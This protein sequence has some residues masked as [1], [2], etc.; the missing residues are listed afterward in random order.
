MC[1]STEAARKQRSVGIGTFAARRGISVREEYGTP[2]PDI[3]DALRWTLRRLGI[4]AD[5]RD[6]LPVNGLAYV[7]PLPQLRGAIVLRP[8]VP[9]PRWTLAHEIGH[10]MLGDM[11]RA[12]LQLSDTNDFWQ[13]V[14]AERAANAFA[15]T[16]LLPLDE[17]CRQF[18][19]DWTRSDIAAFHG[20]P[21]EVVS[22]RLELSRT[23]KETCP[24]RTANLETL[25]L[26]RG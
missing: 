15:A 19:E 21:V 9:Y 24:N 7:T 3:E 13:R 17:L 16:F 11:G 22:L 6:D 23:L 12:H 18:G 14:P 26:R 20:V 4:W 8:D 2:S 10:V 25:L 5:I 1:R